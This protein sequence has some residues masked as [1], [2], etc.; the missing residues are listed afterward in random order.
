M[1]KVCE[2]CSDP[3]IY[4]NKSDVGE[5]HGEVMVIYTVRSEDDSYWKLVHT[6]EVHKDL[7]WK[8]EQNGKSCSS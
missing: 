5:C 6:C 8:R 2:V 7:Y 1:G 3:C 4:H